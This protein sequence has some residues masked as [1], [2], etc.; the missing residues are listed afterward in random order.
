MDLGPRA[1]PSGKTVPLAKGE[2]VGSCG[3]AVSSAALEII[4]R[5]ERHART[6]PDADAYREINPS[7]G[8]DRVLT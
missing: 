3:Y 1:N 5:L 7:G 8:A 2:R 6:R 4:R